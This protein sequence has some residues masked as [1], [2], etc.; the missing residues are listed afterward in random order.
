MLGTLA[1]QPFV[2]SVTFVQTIRWLD[3]LLFGLVAVAAAARL[4]SSAALC[5]AVLWLANPFNDYGYIGGSFLRYNFA[6]ALLLAWFCLDRGRLKSAGLWLA[7]AA[8]LRIFPALFAAGLLLHDLA[9]PGRAARR[10]ALRRHAPL[11]ASFAVS[12]AAIAAITAFTPAPPEH[13]VWQDFLGRISVHARALASNAVGID[14]ALA[15]SREQSES[16]RRE[17][18]AEG[19]SVP[20]EDLVSANL[21]ERKTART[22]TTLLLLAATCLCARRLPERYA[23]FLGFPLLFSLMYSSHYYYLSLGMLGLLFHDHRAA[24]LTLTGGF[25]AAALLATPTGFDDEVLRFAWV[26]VATAASLIALGWVATRPAT[27]PWTDTR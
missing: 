7:V 18:F 6:L 11:Y 26:S 20:W 10:Q 12:G 23:L 9:R 17:A 3:L 14:S 16:A 1:N 22:L 19:E 21:E 27:P 13:N 24:L 25:G 5:F 8:H 2:S 4:G 15:Y